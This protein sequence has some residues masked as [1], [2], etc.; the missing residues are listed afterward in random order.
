MW[1]AV[2]PCGAEVR[3]ATTF[4]QMDLP[5]NSPTIEILGFILGLLE[6]NPGGHFLYRMVEPRYPAKPFFLGTIKWK[7]KLGLAL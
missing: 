6:V 4:G 3:R 5:E 7:K 2:G 1:P